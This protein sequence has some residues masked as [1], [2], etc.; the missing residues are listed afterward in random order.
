[1]HELRLL[2]MAL[3]WPF[4]FYIVFIVA[5][6]PL[7][8]ILSLWRY[9]KI[10]YLLEQQALKRNGTVTG[11]FLLPELKC[12]Y[13]G[14]PVLI[15]SVPGSRYRYAKT[16]VGITLVK[17]APG[18]IAIVRE[19]MGTRLGKKFGTADVQLGNDEFDREFLIKTH[20]EAFARTLVNI[21]LQNALLDLKDEK[22]R[23]I[24]QGTWLTVQLPTVV[25]SEETYDQLFSLAFSFVDR[26]KNL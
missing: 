23:I 24:V 19:S 22:P 14:L 25:K 6:F 12:S 3:D 13:Q 15:T 17:P 20:D 10:K 9:R 5:I 16:E 4:I 8:I 11:S 18:N 26:L 21:S 1:M 7:I 2:K